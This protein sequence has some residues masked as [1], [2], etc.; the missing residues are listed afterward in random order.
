MRDIPVAI[1]AADDLVDF[2]FVNT[3]LFE[4][5]KSNKGKKSHSSCVGGKKNNGQSKAKQGNS[6][7]KKSLGCFILDRPH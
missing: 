5:E 1:A 3:S 4:L 7:G 2:R 6:Q